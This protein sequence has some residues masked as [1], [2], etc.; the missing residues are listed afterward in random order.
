M[1]GFLSVLEWNYTLTFSDGW[2]LHEAENSVKEKMHGAAYE[3]MEYNAGFEPDS[4]KTCDITS[5]TKGCNTFWQNW[6]NSG[7]LLV[8]TVQRDHSKVISLMA[9]SRK[10]ANIGPRAI[11]L[12]RQL[13]KTLNHDYLCQG[14]VPHLF[15]YS[16]G[17]TPMLK[18][19]YCNPQHLVYHPAPISSIAAFQEI[20]GRLLSMQKSHGMFLCSVLPNAFIV[21]LWCT[22]H[23][24]GT[25]ADRSSGHSLFS[26]RFAYL[27]KITLKT[28]I[29]MHCFGIRGSGRPS[30]VF[31]MLPGKKDKFIAVSN[32]ACFSPVSI[33][34]F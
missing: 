3:G 17:T 28:P 16:F 6:C 5:E 9:D 22:V 32:T 33:M 2:N 15:T 20:T 25:I 4:P 8:C 18:F 23:L 30:T 19:C 13:H 31:E 27:R 1:A 7:S 11:L 21:W 26:G 12:I 10:Y 24:I 29:P 34:L 14:R